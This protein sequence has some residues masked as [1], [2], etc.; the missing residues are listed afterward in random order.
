M[1]IEEI[2]LDILKEKGKST[3]W[4]YM[5]LGTSYQNFNKIV[6]KKRTGNPVR[7]LYQNSSSGRG[8]EPP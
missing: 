1:K 5:Q 2:V 3:F 7:F 8:V 6:N 4:L